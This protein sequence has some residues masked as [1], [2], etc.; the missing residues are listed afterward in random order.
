MKPDTT[1]LRFTPEHGY[2]YKEHQGQWYRLRISDSPTPSEPQGEDLELY[3]Y[4]TYERPDG[5]YVKD[6]NGIHRYS[7]KQH[8]KEIP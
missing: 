7:D 5:L 8:V 6:E 2:L 1:K 4:G 3:P